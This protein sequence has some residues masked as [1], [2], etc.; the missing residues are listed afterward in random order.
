MSICTEC[1]MATAEAGEYHPYA[2][3]VLEKAG[4]NPWHE[5]RMIALQVGLPDPG[6]RPPL[7]TRVVAVPA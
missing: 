2:F 1:G 5:V 3:C 6:V 7:V 4:L